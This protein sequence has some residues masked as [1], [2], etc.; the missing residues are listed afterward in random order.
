ML[1]LARTAAADTPPDSDSGVSVNVGPLRNTQGT[2][3]CRLHTSSAGFPRDSQ[4]TTSRRVK[5][6][7]TLARCTFE[8]L[9]SGTYALVVHHD[10][11][12]NRKLD[13]NALGIPVEGYGASN[14]RTRALRAPT[15]ED[16]KFEVE[17]GMTRELSIN[18]RY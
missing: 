1:F 16:S 5:V 6:T 11:N 8:K 10:E 14:N 15:W 7:G 2:V 4:G 13:K 17:R 12:D 9:R 18:P 3:A